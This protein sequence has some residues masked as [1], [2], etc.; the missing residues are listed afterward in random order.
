MGYVD[1][2]HLPLPLPP[3]LHQQAIA[4]FL[5]RE[6][7]RI[8]SIIQLKQRQIELL[9][10]KRVALITQA[11]TKGL[12]PNVKMKDSGVEWLGE[13][14]EHWELRRV[15]QFT[16][17]IRSGKTPR[18]GAEVYQASGVPLIRSQNVH[19]GEL[20][21]DDVAFI[22]ETIDEEMSNTRVRPLDLLLNITGASI[23]RCALVPDPFPHANVNQHVCIVRVK[24][25]L[26]DPGFLSVALCS[27]VVQDQIMSTQV[28]ASR[29]G[30]N[31]EEVGGLLLAVP[32]DLTEQAQIAEAAARVAVD[33]QASSRTISRSI[34]LLQ[35]YRSALISAAVTGQ[36]DVRGEVSA[37]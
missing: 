4:A 12:D 37:P 29:Q 11:V 32:P 14:P 5:D 35:E 10:E 13:I 22:D 19:F 6:T 18:G 3:V 34:E 24:S 15:K 26:I 1:L 8:D 16:S 23:G 7:S 28:G 2:K 9:E 27:Q 30:L 20:R 36:I 21:L 17:V 31:F 25:G 33:T